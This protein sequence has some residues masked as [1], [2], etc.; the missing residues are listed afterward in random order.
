VLRINALLPSAQSGVV[1]AGFKLFQNIFSDD[2]NYNMNC[3]AKW[4]P[5]AARW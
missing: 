2:D 4:E 3:V 5:L 1:A